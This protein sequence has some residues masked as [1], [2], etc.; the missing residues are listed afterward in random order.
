[1]G[2]G[3]GGGAE[4]SDCFKLKTY[5]RVIIMAG[6]DLKKDNPYRPWETA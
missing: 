1:M 6:M 5:S 2:R 4:C 3:K